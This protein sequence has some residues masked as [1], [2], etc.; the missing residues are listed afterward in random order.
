MTAISA[1]ELARWT[2]VALDLEAPTP[3]IEWGDFGVLRF[4]EPFFDD[5]VAR[6]AGGDPP[7]PLVRTGLDALVALDQAPSLDPSGLIFHLSRCGSTLLAR[8]LGQV[9]GCVVVSEP[10]LINQVLL[11]S[12]E[13]VDEDTRVRLLRLLIRA[14]G[15]QRLGDERHLVVKLSSWN[16]RQLAL[17]ERAFPAAPRIWLQ[18]RPA[19]VLASLL[20]ESPEWLRFRSTPDAA[21][22]LFGIAEAELATLDATAFQA[23]VL[24]ALLQAAG[25]GGPLLTV[26]HADLPAAAWTVVAP[27]FGLSPDDRDLAAMQRQA[28]LDAKHATPRPFA[29]SPDRAAL[30]DAVARLVAAQLDP[31]YRAVAAGAP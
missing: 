22:A 24:S 17:F 5:T 3:W 30:P 11:A 16:V 20:A 13:I 6:W 31:L 29:R 18:R 2:P 8:L 28:G 19:E 7:P 14:L 9:A 27:R 25:D 4:S 21:G 23:R 1:T 15:R 26:D 10:S 12:P